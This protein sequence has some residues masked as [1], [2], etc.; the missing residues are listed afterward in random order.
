VPWL[1]AVMTPEQRVIFTQMQAVMCMVEGYS[2]HVM[3]AVGKDVLPRYTAISRAF[4]RRR[5]Q[6]GQFD[7]L[8]ARLTG[9]S[10]KLEQYRLGEEFI[11]AIVASHGHEQAKKIWAGPEFLPTMEEI[12]SPAT[13]AQRVLV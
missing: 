12:R 9:L 5:S 1:E 13:W 4:E 2:N 6:R 10:M 8:F 11:D 7:Q 3:N